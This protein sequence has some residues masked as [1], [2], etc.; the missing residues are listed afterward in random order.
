MNEQ[1]QIHIAILGKRNLYH[2]TAKN[3][4]TKQIKNEFLKPE[5]A[6]TVLTNWNDNGFTTW[7]SINDKE[8]DSI[9]GVIALQDYWVDID[10]RPKGIDDRPATKEEL[11]EALIR[12]EKLKGYIENQFAA[13]GFLA[14]SGN[15][16]HIHFPLPRFEIPPEMREQV[17]K[18]IRHFAKTTSKVVNANID[19]TYDISRRATLIGTVNRKIKDAPL[20]TSW[21]KELL[22]N[23]LED[24][25]Q[26]VEKARQQNQTLLETILSTEEPKQ[27]EANLAPS[28][29]KHIDIEQLCQVNPKVYTLYKTA[30]GTNRE[31]EKYN[32]KSRSEAEAG[33]IT[34]LVME[35]FSDQEIRSLMENCSLGKWQEKADSYRT[36]T[37]EHARQQAGKYIKERETQNQLIKEIAGSNTQQTQQEQKIN[38]SDINPVLIAKKIVEKY[39]FV[40][41]KETKMLWVYDEQQSI[42]TQDA[43]DIIKSEIVRLLDDHAKA[44]FYIDVDFWIRYSAPKIKMNPKPEYLGVENGILNVITKEL[45]PS[46]EARELYVTAKIPTK[47]DPA[48]TCP[49]IQQFLNDILDQPQQR[50]SQEFIGY[51]LFRTHSF[52]KG[53]IANGPTGTGK[54]VHQN[55]NTALI[56]EE[57][58]SNQ[59]IQAINHNRFAPAELYNKMANFCDDMPAS[60]VKITGPFKMATGGGR[61]SGERKGKDPFYF[62]NKAKFWLNCN[63]LPP[64]QKS[65]DCDAYYERLIIVDYTHQMKNK[66]NPNLINELTTP[67]ELSGYLNYALEGLQR[68]LTQKHFSETMTQ[69]DVRAAYI[70]RTDSAKYYVEN[71]IEVTDENSD[72]IFNDILFQQ[73]VKTCHNEGVKPMNKGELINAVQ[74]YCPGALHTKIR[75][76]PNKSPQSAWRYIKIKIPVKQPVTQTKIFDSP[77]PKSVPSVPPVPPPSIPQEHFEKIKEY[78]TSIE[79]CK[80]INELQPSG[81]NGTDGT[82]FK[83]DEPLNKESDRGECGSCKKFG[84]GECVYPSG[85][86]AVKADYSWSYNCNGYVSN[87]VLPDYPE[88]EKTNEE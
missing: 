54:T 81:T 70:K 34:I 16:F 45:K 63:K 69:Q 72:F 73:A 67:E 75:P 53:Y 83:P 6:I 7:L 48:A 57:N 30:N 9:Q 38:I 40:M 21:D 65:E 25:L 19:K 78:S 46:S 12:A 82:K 58:I 74:Q 47:Y 37:L 2:S 52:R 29:E 50:L 51:C 85:P 88:E 15:G 71:F 59:T 17:N 8:V 23:G 64:I 66:E 35:G 33:L 77:T 49:K 61:M 4:Q 13:I 55:L 76:E 18:K 28:K 20:Q 43:E 32:Y 31:Y 10:S 56:G 39:S 14:N 62:R 22:K 24:A 86:D 11:Q 42:Y 79:I 44:R 80:S 3:Y 84:T 27:Q 36:L 68:L 5:E 26:Q 87:N 1:Q 41:D 60:I